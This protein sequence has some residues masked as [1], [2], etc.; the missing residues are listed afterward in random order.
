MKKLLCRDAG[1]VE[2]EWEF[3]GASDDEVLQKLRD[4]A[5]QMHNREPLDEQARGRIQSG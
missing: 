4:H 2:C 3:L 5:R 1:F